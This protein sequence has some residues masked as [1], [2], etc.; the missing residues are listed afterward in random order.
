MDANIIYVLR[1][2]CPRL[3][4]QSN[5]MA[6]A[7]RVIASV[8]CGPMWNEHANHFQSSY[9]ISQQL[10]YVK[11][12]LKMHPRAR[13]A[14]EVTTPL[15]PH[16]SYRRERAKGDKCE[17]TMA[18]F[19]ERV[20]LEYRFAVEA[21]GIRCVCRLL[22]VR[23][24]RQTVRHSKNTIYFMSAI[25]FST[26]SSSPSALFVA[27]DALRRHRRNKSGRKHLLYFS[28]TSMCV[29]RNE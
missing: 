5:P 17:R 20:R 25:R 1:S 4:H 14:N 16:V 6:F 23:R 27:I 10:H 22:V 28:T 18:D 11:F 29:S 2:F 15:S 13:H 7:S 3:W 12:A 26:S 9:A 24:T 8:F 19:D 21:N